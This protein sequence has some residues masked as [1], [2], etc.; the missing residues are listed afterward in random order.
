MQTYFPLFRSSFLRF[1]SSI[2]GVRTN[3]KSFI[4]KSWSDTLVEAFNLKG[5]NFDL[6]S[7]DE[8]I[9]LKCVTISLDFHSKIEVI[10]HIHHYATG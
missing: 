6:A 3:E 4:T 2:L 7:Y 8:S 1:V 10:K 9:G 5:E